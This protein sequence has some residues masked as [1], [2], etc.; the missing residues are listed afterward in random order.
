[1]LEQRLQSASH[2]LQVTPNSTIHS[3]PPLT[4]P[5]LVDLW[6][7]PQTEVYQPDMV[8]YMGTPV[9][10]NLTAPTEEVITEHSSLLEDKKE[11][12]IKVSGKKVEN[13]QLSHS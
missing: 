10:G 5:P 12:E 13:R 2:S 1:M 3:L 11:G 8:G 7:T 4:H 9:D 6:G